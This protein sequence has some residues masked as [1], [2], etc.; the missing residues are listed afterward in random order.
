MGPLGSLVDRCESSDHST[1][2]SDNLEAMGLYQPSCLWETGEDGKPRVRK[3][4]MGDE[5][6]A[7]LFE[8]TISVPSPDWAA[9]EQGEV[10]VPPPRIPVQAILCMKTRNMKKSERC[11]VLVYDGTIGLTWSLS[12]CQSTRIAG[13]SPYAPFCSQGQRFCW[14]LGPDPLITHSGT[15]GDRST[16]TPISR[17]RA[18]RSGHHWAGAIRILRT[19]LWPRKISSTRHRIL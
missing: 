10:R 4:V 3:T 7:H 1:Y 11:H 12:H 17:E 15:C 18:V 8:H 14:T 2:H 16:S 13:S 9:R 6:R 5:I 19:L